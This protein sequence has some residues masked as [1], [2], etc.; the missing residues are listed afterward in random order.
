MGPNFRSISDVGTALGHPWSKAEL[1]TLDYVPYPEDVLVECRN[2]HLL[3]PYFETNLVGLKTNVAD[4][5]RADNDWFI[6]EKDIFARD[7]HTPLD[8]K[9]VLKECVRD[10]LGGTYQ[11]QLTILPPTHENPQ[12]V[13][14]VFMLAIEVRLQRDQELL[15][16]WEKYH[17]RTRSIDCNGNV[18]I[19]LDD[20]RIIIG[21]CSDKSQRERIGLSG[22]LK[23]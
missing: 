11:D 3:V 16:Y 13:D 6:E 12:A 2:T 10:S 18:Y 4:A 5:M 8:W 14:L 20:Y 19:G 21:S 17:G 9:L 15:K 1:K 23:F 7:E 22:I